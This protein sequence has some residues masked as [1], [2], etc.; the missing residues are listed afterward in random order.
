MTSADAFNRNIGKLQGFQ[1]Q[2]DIISG[3]VQVAQYGDMNHVVQKCE[4]GGHAQG[5]DFVITGNNK[6]AFGAIGHVSS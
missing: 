1:L 3:L 5:L 4:P 2:L 6:Y